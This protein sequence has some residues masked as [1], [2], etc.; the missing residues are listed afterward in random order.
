MTKIQSFFQKRARYQELLDEAIYVTRKPNDQQVLREK[1]KEVNQAIKTARLLNEA[2][3]KD[4]V[5]A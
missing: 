1:I 2:E 3:S 4:Q 5:E